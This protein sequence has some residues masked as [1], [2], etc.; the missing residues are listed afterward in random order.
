M[1]R[2]ESVG[3]V[4]FHVLARQRQEQKTEGVMEPMRRS[5]VRTMLGMSIQRRA[6]QY[7]SLSI[8]LLNFF[9]FL[10]ATRLVQ[11]SGTL[12]ESASSCRC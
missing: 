11:H 9:L 12:V 2:H 7:R 8:D 3:E 4:E 5:N 6:D 10:G 1:V